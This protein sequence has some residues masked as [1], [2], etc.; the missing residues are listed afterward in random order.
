MSAHQ[1]TSASHPTGMAPPQSIAPPQSDRGLERRAFPRIPTAIRVQ[2]VRP[3][4]FADAVCS[5]TLHNLS[6]SGALLHA[7]VEV[8]VGE[9]IMIRP[10]ERG[11]GFGSEI[12][13]IV[14]RATSRCG[15][16]YTLACRFP[17]PLDYAVIRSFT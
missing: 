16:R 13:A 17:E 2:I 3:D 1:L 9:W 7:E 4:V 15:K 5:A 11:F 10:A 12:V 6:Q 8:G 14:E